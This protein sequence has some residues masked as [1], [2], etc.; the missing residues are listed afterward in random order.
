M[1]P[2]KVLED[3][4]T[5]VSEVEKDFEEVRDDNPHGNEKDRQEKVESLLSEVHDQ[6]RLLHEIAEKDAG[7]E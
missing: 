5:E 2:E 4:E 1:D 6:I 7:K 3:L